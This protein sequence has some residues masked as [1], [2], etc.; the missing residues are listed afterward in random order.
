M[1][2]M[3]S[4]AVTSINLNN[5]YV[6]I[7]FYHFFSLNYFLC[8][9][10]LSFCSSNNNITL[11]FYIHAYHIINK[12]VKFYSQCEQKYK[13]FH[14]N[15]TFYFFYQFF[16]L[17]FIGLHKY[18][19]HDHVTL[20]KAILSLYFFFFLLFTSYFCILF[21]LSFTPEQNK[22]FLPPLYSSLQNLS[23]IF[24]F[25]LYRP[26]HKI[27]VSFFLS[28]SLSFVLF[29]RLISLSI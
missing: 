14:K 4:W 10:I 13:A 3:C 27:L 16:P 29:S 28:L 26:L 7:I 18:S 5:T 25:L 8:L 17:F 12:L 20:I 2:V 6:N 22:I 21:F 23:L 11:T 1:S 15:L 24:F 9:S 19:V